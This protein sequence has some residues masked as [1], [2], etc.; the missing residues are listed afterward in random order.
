VVWT[1]GAATL[2]DTG[3]GVVALRWNTKMNSIGG[4][5]LEGVMQSIAIAEERFRG[6]VI[7]NAT[8]TFSAG[9][10]VG[11]IFMLAVEEEWDELDFAVRQFQAG[12]MR[13]RYSSIPV[14]V[15][16]HGLT[17]GGGCEMCLHADAVQ[18]A[19]ET[20]IG[21]VEVGV[22]LIPGGGG[23]KEMAL[24]VSDRNMKEDVELNY[25]Q[26]LFINIGTAKV[27]TSAAE[28][29]SM[30]IL[31]KGIDGISMNMDRRIADAKRKVLLLAEQGYTQPAP[32]TDI[33]VQG[34][35]GIGPLLSG[36]H[37]MWRGNYISDY[38][39]LIAEKLAM[40]ICGGDLSQPTAVSEQYL[41][42]L[43]REAFLSL[44]GQRKTL[45]RLQSILQ[46]GKPLRN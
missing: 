3:D 27:A 12:T 35:T 2:Y 6:L 20:Y 40:V 22:G 1:N 42:D 17:L 32:R 45:E 43:E 24:R 18:A 8:D 5:V 21:L 34:R 23:T 46:T 15:A 7:A 19:A 37:A 44:C 30:G 39:K 10:N 9:A 4:E 16:P 25:L 41:L 13:L 28:A 33:M 36:I 14:V 38:D 31:R 11:L 26:Q 29:F